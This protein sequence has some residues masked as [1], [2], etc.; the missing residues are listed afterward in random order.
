MDRTAENFKAETTPFFK[1]LV[2]QSSNLLQVGD[3]R[4]GRISLKATASSGLSKATGAIPLFSGLY[5]ISDNLWLGGLFSGYRAGDD[6]IILSGYAAEILTGDLSKDGSPW[7][8][9]VSRR[10]VEGAE[11]FNFKTVSVALCRRI[12]SG[13]TLF[14]YGLGFA[15]YDAIVH[16]ILV[17]DEGI[18]RRL[19]GQVNMLSGGVERSLGEFVIALTANAGREGGS[20]MVSL[21]KLIKE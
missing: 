17:T 18:P 21:S 11:D 7:S 14:Y 4:E 13:R 20:V 6:V 2:F 10:A 19:E 15:F 5:R 12:N 9:E 8:V 16:D 3:G 1:Q